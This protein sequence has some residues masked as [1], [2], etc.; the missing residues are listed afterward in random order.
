MCFIL[1][2]HLSC[3]SLKKVSLDCNAEFNTGLDLENIKKI[4]K[5]NKINR[6]LER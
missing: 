4:Q 5:Q 3:L 2:Y 6:S 1:K